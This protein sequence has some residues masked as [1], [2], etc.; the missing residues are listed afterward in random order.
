MSAYFRVGR[1]VICIQRTGQRSLT[2]TLRSTSGEDLG[3]GQVTVDFPAI[4][5]AVVSTIHRDGPVGWSFSSVKR[6]ARLVTNR[7]AI[8]K[9]LR[10]VTKIASDPRL[11]KIANAA[12]T[13][14]PPLGIPASIAVKAAQ[15]YQSAQAGDPEAK[16]RIV[17]IVREADAGSTPAQK[18]ARAVAVFSAADASGASVSGW[19]DNMRRGWMVNIP[20]RSNMAAGAV[21]RS[22]PSTTHRA[23]Y[24]LHL[25]ALAKGQR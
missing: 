9:V 1:V 13:I 3:E 22:N 5:Q 21:D 17:N 2:Y 8:K 23:L 10:D 25:N 16:A 14:Y 18:V 6:K 15:L 12:A 24:N 11:Q 20:Y 7:V 19:I 4:Y